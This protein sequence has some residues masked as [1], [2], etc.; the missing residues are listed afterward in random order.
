MEVTV[1]TVGPVYTNC[2]IVNKEN[3]STGCVVIDPGEDAEK[4]ASY[5]RKKNLTC[6]GILLTHGHFDHI[7][8]VSEL[9]S[10]V[11]GKIYA[12]EKEK[13]L[14]ADP[15]LNSSA[16]VGYEVGIEADVW[17]RDG[18]MLE[19]AGMQ[20]QVIHTPGHTTGGCCYYAESDKLLFSGDTIFMES[21]GRT[22]LPTG[23]SR[24]LIDSVRNKVLTLPNDVTIYPGHGPKTT[25]AYEV[26]NNPYA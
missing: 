20:F 6:E 26:A 12:Y 23:N 19:I 14:L 3:D 13:E 1:L 11:G 8:A 18:Q 24:E 2:Y 10:L 16:M 17:L 9:H 4:I 15:M 21:I 22:D 25:V 7:T 5:I